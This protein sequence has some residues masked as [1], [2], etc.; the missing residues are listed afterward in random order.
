MGPG[1]TGREQ[2]ELGKKEATGSK[3]NTLTAGS[4]LRTQLEHYCT[5]GVRKYID[6]KYVNMTPS[7]MYVYLGRSL[8]TNG[9]AC[10]NVWSTYGHMVRCIENVTIIMFVA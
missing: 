10:E 1:R 2:L 6:A 3:N 8:P 7:R 9:C 4:N 5:C